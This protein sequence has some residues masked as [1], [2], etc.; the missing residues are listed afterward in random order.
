MLQRAGKQILDK[1]KKLIPGGSGEE[2]V[3]LEKSVTIGK[4][5]F[6]LTNSD[7]WKFLQDEILIPAFLR[8]KQANYHGKTPE[9]K[10]EGRIGMKIFDEDI[11][12]KITELIDRGIK[13]ETTLN[14][15][16]EKRG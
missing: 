16:K 11:D 4:I 6:G 3:G 15:L 13:A 12:R 2:T 10:E 1:I 9:E 8:Y 7:S 5:L 14:K